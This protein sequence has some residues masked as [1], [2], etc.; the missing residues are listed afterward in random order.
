M[1]VNSELVQS[2]KLDDQNALD[3]IHLMTGLQKGGALQS[4]Y[5]N[6][7]SKVSPHDKF[8]KYHQ[9]LEDLGLNGIQHA[10]DERERQELKDSIGIPQHNQSLPLPDPNGNNFPPNNSPNRKKDHQI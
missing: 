10:I 2:Q 6:V 1:P 5:F 4:D 3:K 8:F 9:E 7:I